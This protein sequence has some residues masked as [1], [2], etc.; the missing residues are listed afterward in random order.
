MRVKLDDELALDNPCLVPVP[1][2]VGERAP[3][4]LDWPL[5]MSNGDRAC[6]G[7]VRWALRWAARS[8]G[9]LAAS[10]MCSRPRTGLPAIVSPRV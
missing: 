10:G 3:N 9:S 5:P 1:S 6:G 8:P 2:N 7:G 4:K